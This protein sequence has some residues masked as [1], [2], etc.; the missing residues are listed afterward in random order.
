[1]TLSQTV[2]CVQ[3]NPGEYME[4]LNVR[5]A[6]VNRLVAN[7]TPAQIKSFYACDNINTFFPHTG[8]FVSDFA[9]GTH[10]NALLKRHK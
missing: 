5:H 1:M 10:V 8:L 2:P 9:V 6:S 3:P 7:L 4:C